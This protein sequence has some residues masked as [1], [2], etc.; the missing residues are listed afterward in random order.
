VRSHPKERQ[1]LKR[2]CFFWLQPG[3]FKV[4]GT[5]VWKYILYVSVSIVMVIMIGKFVF[6]IASE[7]TESIRSKQVAIELYKHYLLRLD[8]I[9]KEHADELKSVKEVN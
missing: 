7:R 8:E 1:G 5:S 6:N 9:S 3:S 4:T 2:L